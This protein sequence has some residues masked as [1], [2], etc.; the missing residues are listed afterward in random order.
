MKQLLY[1]ILLI[2]ILLSACTERLVNTTGNVYGSVRDA[3]T[4]APL[5]NCS[6][7][8]TPLGLS[9]TTGDSGSFYLAN[10]E[11]GVYTIQASRSGY[12]TNSTHLTVTPNN[13][14]RVDLL[15]TDEASTKGRI[16]G[17][18]IDANTQTPLSGC[19]VILSPGNQSKV[20]DEWGTFLFDNLSPGTYSLRITKDEYLDQAKYDI[21]VRADTETPVQI[22]LYDE[23]STKGTITGTVC[24]YET[25]D[26][27]EG[28]LVTLQPGGASQLTD[29]D[30][31]FL[32]EEL[33]PA[34]YEI[35]VSK[36]NYSPS[37]KNVTVDSGQNLFVKILLPKESMT[38]G[39][40]TGTVRDYDTN[41][42]LE[43][44]L[45]TLQPEGTSQ[46]TDS[47]GHFL[48]EELIPADYEIIVSKK[49]Y[50]AYTKKVTID[51]GKNLSVEI[52]LSKESMTQGHYCPVKVDK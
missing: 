1:F 49:N 27:L 52:L 15:L 4:G 7:L 6:V 24:D 25:N 8:L 38:K 33:I 2:V 37:T 20:T 41:D 14:N 40:I 35:T 47:E 10:I 50:S 12:I 17:S 34:E 9:T 30:G 46:M 22:L 51:P 3:T 21:I 31:R 36:K 39:G 42:V 32:F 11:G 45:I 26:V 28:C 13:D 29:S 18:V 44:C 43:G 16:R 5:N 48:F 23:S 19:S